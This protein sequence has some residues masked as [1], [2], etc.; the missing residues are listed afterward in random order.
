M[1]RFL[2]LAAAGLMALVATSAQAANL[3]IGTGGPTGNYFGMT[4]DIGRYCSPIM[5][6]AGHSLEVL[7][8]KGSLANLLGMTQKTYSI[9]IVQEDALRFM[10]KSQGR[11]INEKKMKIITGMHTE[12]LHLLIP[13]GWK[14]ESDS[15]FFGGLMDKMGGKKPIK[16][17]VAT[18]K[19]QFIGAW[20]GSYVSA[21]AM[22]NF[23]GL[24]AKIVD[25]GEKNAVNQFGGKTSPKIPT[26][27]V[28]GVPYKP[29]T[30]LLDSGKYHL[31][32]LDAGAF[33]AKAD[34]Y[35]RASANYTVAGKLQPTSTVGVR[36][37]MIGKVFRSKKK[38]A[39]MTVLAN[40]VAEQLG[41]LADD[42][43]S[44][45]NWE[46]VWDLEE[47]GDQPNWDYFVR[48]TSE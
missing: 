4:N 36:A 34:F 23:L 40:C 7:N 15:G 28:G 41:D 1:K 27:I 2:T 17:D 12:V 33:K 13:K 29:V 38:N 5:N 26:L 19:G 18:L 45:A 37:L 14:P 24:G 9:G 22:N 42:E 25:L 35:S 48:P 6:E 11:A 21:Q 47:K 46:S 32:G 8:S 39:A 16:L 20:G 43:S 3:K 44:N 10:A 31:V 30:A